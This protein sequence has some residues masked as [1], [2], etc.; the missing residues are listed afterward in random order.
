MVA[1]Q[2]IC[3]LACLYR[4]A[5]DPV[6]VWLLL[7]RVVR[8]GMSQ[9]EQASVPCV[10]EAFVGRIH[11]RLPA[12]LEVLLLPAYLQ[13]RAHAGNPNGQNR[14]LFPINPDVD[15][16]SDVGTHIHRDRRRTSGPL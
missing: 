14:T 15:A 4:R 7:S 10:R 1:A 2:Q 9:G 5:C 3:F 13:T 12:F 6:R 8:G 11:T 16:L